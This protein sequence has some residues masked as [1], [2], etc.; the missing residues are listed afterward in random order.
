[1]WAVTRNIPL[2][3]KR[4]GGS[5]FF[6][7]DEDHTRFIA[8]QAKIRLAADFEDNFPIGAVVE[9]CGDSFGNLIEERG[10]IGGQWSALDPGQ[11]IEGGGRIGIG[12]V[13]RD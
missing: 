8:S 11:A 6:G 9:M 4:R 2:T 12:K 5:G 3:A 7:A 1:M 13:E 10:R